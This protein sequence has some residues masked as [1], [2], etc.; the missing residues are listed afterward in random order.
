MS[1]DLSPSQITANQNDYN[2]ANLATASVLR[3]T[4]DASRNITSLAGGADGR[5]ITIMNVG[6]FPIVL[7]NDDGST[8]TAANRFALPGDVTLAAKQNVILMYD[9]TASRWRQI[10]NSRLGHRR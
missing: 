7:K 2:P 4:T 3:L 10:A 9:S 1:G 5:I 8:G 6:S